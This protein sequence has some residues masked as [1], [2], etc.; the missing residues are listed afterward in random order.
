MSAITANTNNTLTYATQTF[1]LMLQQD[2][3]SWT[4]LEL[5]QLGSTTTITDTT[6][7]LASKQMVWKR[8]RITGGT[9][10]GLELTIT[11]NKYFNLWSDNSAGYII[12]IY[13]TFS[14]TKG[15]GI[16]FSWLF[17]LQT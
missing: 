8:V 2:V 17:G 12:S 9:G 10:Q 5:L 15:A 3:E 11:S 14:T 16:E 4:R 1:S 6:K 7:K 13:Y